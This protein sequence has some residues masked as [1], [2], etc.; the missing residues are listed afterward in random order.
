[1]R[2]VSYDAMVQLMGSTPPPGGPQLDAY[3]EVLERRLEHAMGAQWMLE[4]NL[5]A[6]M[7]PNEL[8]DYWQRKAM[9]N[10]LRAAGK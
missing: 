2:T 3:C 10:S 5:L 9:D 6:G 8:F 7:V 4:A 1:M